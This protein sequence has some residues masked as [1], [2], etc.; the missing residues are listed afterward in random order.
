MFLQRLLHQFNFAQS[1]YCFSFAKKEELANLWLKF[2]NSKDIEKLSRKYVFVCEKHCETKYL[3]P[4]KNRTRLL[5]HL[6]PIPTLFSESQKNLPAS[7]LP[8][9][10]DNPRRFRIPKKNLPEKRKLFQN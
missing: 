6:N 3:C 1:A 9:V 4:T 8:K 5:I 2:I 7:V 10:D